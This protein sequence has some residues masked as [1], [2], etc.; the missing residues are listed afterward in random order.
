MDVSNVGVQ[1][2]LII[3][4]MLPIPALPYRLLPALYMR[5]NPFASWFNLPEVF[6]GEMP[7]NFVLPHGIIC[8][9]FG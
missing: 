8:I 5:F 2:T 6:M 7:L 3:K 1:I 9:T 4:S